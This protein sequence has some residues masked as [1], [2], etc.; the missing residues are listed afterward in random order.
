MEASATNAAIRSVEY[1]KV[2]KIRDGHREV[3]ARP[4]A[5]PGFLHTDA[6]AS[7]I[8]DGLQVLG[9]LETGA[10]HDQITSVS[11]AGSID[12]VVRADPLYAACHQLH[13]VS[14]ECVEPGVVDDK[15]TGERGMVRDQ[16]VE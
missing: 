14:H 16:I 3:R 4:V 6:A 5:A 1:E 7:P 2:G 11:L 15:A 12:D 9:D 8:V 10:E 13:V